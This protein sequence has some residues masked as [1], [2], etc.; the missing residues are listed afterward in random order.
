MGL[1]LSE[2]AFGRLARNPIAG[3]VSGQNTD[4][5]ESSTC[6]QDVLVGSWRFEGQCAVHARK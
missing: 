3:F 1:S 6:G 5:G 4:T 2:G